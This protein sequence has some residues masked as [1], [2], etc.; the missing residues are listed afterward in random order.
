MA[1]H[2]LFREQSLAD[3]IHCHLEDATKRAQLHHDPADGRHKGLV[4]LG[5][6]QDALTSEQGIVTDRARDLT[7][8]SREIL[9]RGLI[10]RLCAAYQS[11]K[12]GI[13]VN[14]WIPTAPVNRL[15]RRWMCAMTQSSSPGSS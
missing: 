6:R 14:G 5:R 8:N 11:V 2:R 13:N 10:C 1:P 15:C 12:A 7:G 4:H 3:H 9:P